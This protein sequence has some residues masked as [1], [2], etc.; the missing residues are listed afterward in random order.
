MS[1]HFVPSLQLN[2]LSSCKNSLLAHSVSKLIAYFEA[3]TDLV[4]QRVRTDRGG[5]YIS[6]TVQRF[7]EPSDILHEPTAGYSPEANGLAERH[8]LT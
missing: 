2:W 8:N 3:Q 6:G 5:E 4:V 7:F 1:M